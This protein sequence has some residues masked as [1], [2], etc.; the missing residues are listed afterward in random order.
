MCGFLST[1]LVLIDVEGV[2]VEILV[3]VGQTIRDRGNILYQL[4]LL[5]HLELS[6]R[7]GLWLS[8]LG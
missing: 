8:T 4:S 3:H 2:D 6:E 7:R 1:I 5:Y